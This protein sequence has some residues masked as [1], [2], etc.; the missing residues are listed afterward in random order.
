MNLE[1]TTPMP[2]YKCHKVVG[3]LKIKEIRLDA[4]RAASENRETDGS[5]MLVPEE[6][7]FTPFRVDSQYLVKHKPETGGYYV[8]YKDG[9]ES[10]SPGDVFE[11]GY[12]RI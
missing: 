4:I 11:D 5:A 12:T 7:R 10:F 9:Y 8:R 6:E 1:A 3:A 2:Q